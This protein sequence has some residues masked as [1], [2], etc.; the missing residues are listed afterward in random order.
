MRFLTSAYEFCELMR[1]SREFKVPGWW[2]GSAYR[3]HPCGFF[4]EGLIFTNEWRCDDHCSI[5]AMRNPSEPL[6]RWCHDSASWGNPH[7]SPASGTEV[8]WSN[9]KWLLGGPWVQKA[10]RILAN[11]AMAVSARAGGERLRK[12]AIAHVAVE[13]RKTSLSA[14]AAAHAGGDRG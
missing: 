7:P 13:Q 12:A 2:D 11:L 3:S 9:G 4:A 8:V 6:G 1:L 10:E 14:L 5:R